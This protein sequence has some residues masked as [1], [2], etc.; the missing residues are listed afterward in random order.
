MYAFGWRGT[1]AQENRGER[2][3]YAR[4]EKKGQE[5]GF[6]KWWEP[7]KKEQNFAILRNILQSTKKNKGAGT[8]TE[9]NRS[10]RP[11]VSP[12]F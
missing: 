11:P 5:A 12:H 10:F 2:G 4:R 3:I 6:P 7:G 1:G 9:G 8:P